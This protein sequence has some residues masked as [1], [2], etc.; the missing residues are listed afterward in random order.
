MRKYFHIHESNFLCINTQG[1]LKTFSTGF[2]A[3]I[4]M[5]HSFIKQLYIIINQKEIILYEYLKMLCENEYFTTNIF[6][7]N[8]N[9]DKM[10]VSFLSSITY[11]F[12]FHFLYHVVNSVSILQNNIYLLLLLKK[13]DL[14]IL[15]LCSC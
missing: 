14:G 2:V 9:F 12:S 13:I 5:M 10:F 7:T 11:T 8:R 6:D 1:H 3:F 4:A 15:N